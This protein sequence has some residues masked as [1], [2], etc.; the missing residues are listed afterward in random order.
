M[1]GATGAAHRARRPT[2]EE[3]SCPLYSSSISGVVRAMRPS[4]IAS[5]LVVG[6]LDGMERLKTRHDVAECRFT[7]LMGK[8]SK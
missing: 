1:R 7:K 5:K 4:T 3:V 2:D 6:T 8:R